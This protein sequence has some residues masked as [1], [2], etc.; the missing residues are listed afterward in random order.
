MVARPA[1]LPTV[2]ET[3]RAA[4]VY[5]RAVWVPV[6]RSGRVALLELQPDHRRDVEALADALADLAAVWKREQAAP[7]VAGMRAAVALDVVTAALARAVTLE[8][9]PAA[10][11]AE[12]ALPDWRARAAELADALTRMDAAGL[13]WT[14]DRLG[15]NA[16]D[17]LRALV[18]PPVCHVA[19]ALAWRYAA[20]RM[21]DRNE[22]VRAASLAAAALADEAE[23]ALAEAR[24]AA[25][26]AP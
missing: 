23:E 25:R 13:R 7:T 18:G 4:L 8:V 22:L 15:Q 21:T 16:I 17:T 19:R 24:A 6:R 3:Q 1:E 20:A 26:V 9:A 5:W 14:V 10:A 12:V 2:A 11:L